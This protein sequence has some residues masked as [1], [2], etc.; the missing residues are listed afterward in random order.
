M[1]TITINDCVYKTHPIYDLY[2]ASKKGYM[3][4]IIKK[5]PLKGNMTGS[6]YFDY[7]VRKYGEP[8]QKIYRAHR[9]IWE[10]FNGVIPD[11]MVVDH[12]NE[13]KGDN[14]LCNLQLLTPQQNSK[15]SAE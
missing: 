4:H 7:S 9:F 8:G 14:R 10:N 12:I 1:T 15:K 6:G 5:V 13:N 11:G 2:A 3:I